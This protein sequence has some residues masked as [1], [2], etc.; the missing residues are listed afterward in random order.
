M[1]ASTE[2]V[3]QNKHD[4]IGQIEDSKATKTFYEKLNKLINLG[5]L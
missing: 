1:K 3:F 5:Y 2:L 4:K